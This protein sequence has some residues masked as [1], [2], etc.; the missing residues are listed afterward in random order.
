MSTRTREILSKLFSVARIPNYVAVRTFN[1]KLQERLSGVAIDKD[2]PKLRRAHYFIVPINCPILN[3]LKFTGEIVTTCEPGVVTPNNQPPVLIFSDR[4]LK[5]HSLHRMITSYYIAQMI[6]PYEL[7]LID[8]TINQRFT[9]STPISRLNNYTSKYMSDADRNIVDIN[10]S[11]ELNTY[12]KTDLLPLLCMILYSHTN[13]ISPKDMAEAIKTNKIDNTPI[14]LHRFNTSPNG[15]YLKGAQRITY[16]FRKTNSNYK[17]RMS[18]LTGAAL[19]YTDSN[20]D[21]IEEVLSIYRANEPE[22]FTKFYITEELDV[23]G[24]ME[25][26]PNSYIAPNALYITRNRGNVAPIASR[27]SIV[28]PEVTL[29]NGPRAL[30]EF[31]NQFISEQMLQNGTSLSF[32]G[33]RTSNTAVTLYKE[34]DVAYGALINNIFLYT[35]LDFSRITE[36]NRQ[37]ISIY[38]MLWMLANTLPMKDS[39]RLQMCNEIKKQYI[40]ACLKHGAQ[41]VLSELNKT[42]RDNERTIARLQNDLMLQW[43]EY[44]QKTNTYDVLK[45][46]SQVSLKRLFRAGHSNVH[47]TLELFTIKDYNILIIETRP[48]LYAN[49]I[50][51]PGYRIAIPIF[52]APGNIGNYNQAFNSMPFIIKVAPE[53]NEYYKE[54]CKT[55]DGRPHP[56]TSNPK[57]LAAGAVTF[58][59]KPADISTLT[60]ILNKM[61]VLDM[62]QGNTVHTVCLGEHVSTFYNAML[63][64]DIQQII[65]TVVSFVYSANE[66]DPWGKTIRSFHVVNN[67]T[68]E[69]KDFMALSRPWNREDWG[70]ISYNHIN[71]TI[72]INEPANNNI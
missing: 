31:N 1:P 5:N 50:F 2:V 57:P 30:V 27:L 11:M 53:Y 33:F 43:K 16:M 21:T 71:R 14:F 19:L 56:H 15:T 35:N 48:Y 10:K 45:K 64:M 4:V 67:L 66:S 34:K 32:Y 40:I 13:N 69:V 55:I 49:S 28:L 38:M 9:S 47:R 39:T 52:S 54:L 70:R 63:S 68:P 36:N 29:T 23:V 61:G 24:G 18:W 72:I 46:G 62:H 25:I 7:Y 60:Y 41:N 59:H 6:N 3:E 58:G 8:G 65:T 44:K 51:V 37:D 26:N 22:G 12:T 17:P 42:I 20:M